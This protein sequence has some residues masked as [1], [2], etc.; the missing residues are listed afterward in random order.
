MTKGTEGPVHRISTARAPQAIGAYAQATS[1]EGRLVFVSGQLPLDPVTGEIVAGD[2]E[3]HVKQCMH[4]LGEI[5]KEA[6]L[7]CGNLVK[8]TVYVTDMT[9]FP[10]V[11]RAYQSFFPGEE[12]PAR[13]VVEVSALPRG[14]QVEIEGTAVG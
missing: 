5:L 8:T 3:D 13:A 10:V 2:I 9:L 6:G 12:Y 7:S 14:C 11:N 1:A 4:N